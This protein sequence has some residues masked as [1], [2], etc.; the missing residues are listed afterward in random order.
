MENL[1]IAAQLKGITVVGTGD[2]T[3]PKWLS[4]ISEKLVPA[5]DGLYRIKDDLAARCDQNIPRSCRSTV[6]FVL[7]TEISNIYKKED[8]TR[9]NHNLIVV[10]DIE[11]ANRFSQRLDAIGNIHSDGRPILGLDAKNLL[12]ILLETS[13]HA[14]LIPAHIWTPW[15]SVMG[16]KSGF[17]SIE[18]CFE[19]LS[20]YIFAV[21][22]GLSSDPAMN[23][24]VSSL[25]KYTLISNSDAHSP[26]NLGREAN[27][28]DTE[29]SYHQIFFAIKNKKLKRF[30]GTYEFFPEEGKYH[31]DGHRKC[32]V[33]LSP[34]ESIQNKGIC[35][36]C[37]KPLTLGVL[38][39]VEELA[40]R[41]VN[42]TPEEQ[43]PFYRSIPLSDIL[44][45]ILKTGPKSK[46]VQNQYSSLLNEFGSEYNILHGIST[47]TL[48]S[49]GVPLLAEAIS[50]MRCG[51]LLI[52][53]GFDGEYG[54][55][56][57]FDPGERE[58]LIGQKTLFES[59]RKNIPEQRKYNRNLPQTD[60]EI[61]T[62]ISKPAAVSVENKKIENSELNQ[63]QLQAIQL[64]NRSLLIV[65]GPGTGKTLT[66][67]RRIAHL[68][69]T[70]DVL[71]ENILAVTFTNKAAREM[72]ERLA[73][74]NVDARQLPLITTF[75]GLCYRMLS[76][77]NPLSLEGSAQGS[78]HTVIDE[79][80]QRFY[81]NEAVDLFKS[82]GGCAPADSK[83]VL[84]HIR[85]AKQMLMEPDD[86][87]IADATNGSIGSAADALPGIYGSY[88]ELLTHQRLYD[89]EDL[90]FKTVK[91]LESDPVARKTYQ[92]R[93]R[94]I[95][96]DEF[97]DI[98]LGQHRLLQLLSGPD[99][100]ICAIGDPDQS[101]YGFRGSDTKFFNGF[102]SGFADTGVI[103]LTQNY[104]STRTIVEAS[105]QIIAGQPVDPLLGDKF[106][107]Q[108][109]STKEGFKT[110][111][112]IATA[113]ERAE[114]VAV[115][116]I[117]E[118]MIGGTGFHYVDFNR[119]ESQSAGKES[120]FSDFAVLY[121]TGIQG[122][123]FS[124]VFSAAG[125][126]HQ[127]VN[128]DSVY[129]D[130]GNSGAL[131]LL[132]IFAGAGSFM[133]LERLKDIISPGAPREILKQFR[134][135][136]FEN[137]MN[138]SESLKNVRRLP[139]QGMSK[140]GQK[141]LV[142]FLDRLDQLRQETQ[143]MTICETLQ[144]VAGQ[145]RPAGDV[146]EDEQSTLA[147]RAIMDLSERYGRRRLEFISALALQTDTDMYMPRSERVALMTM[148]SAKGLEFPVVF[149][150]GCENGYIPLQRSGSSAADIDEERRLFYVAMTRAKERLFFIF[151]RE[152]RIYG[153]KEKREASPFIAQIDS[154]LKEAQASGEKRKKAQR[155][156]K[157]F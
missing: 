149:I 72:H 63:E 56:Q 110:I 25:D 19:E 23:R 127:L 119:R 152:R 50:R 32:S 67:T 83:S 58:H 115:G 68:M 106:F 133:D 78:S 34:K 125:I 41:P 114:A 143:N 55:V 24:R 61:K 45:E 103:K 153:K 150:C 82:K 30:L 44:S 26:M 140:N 122:K 64:N 92:D 62:D 37:E 75:H 126:P 113:S 87:R 99:V 111:T 94:F 4:E 137:R 21:E 88:Q 136:S 54:K 73:G 151:A 11:T 18:E 100:R 12:E 43:P 16:S 97:Q 139:I 9:K 157:L 132:K 29:L 71:P 36:K 22:T 69:K 3:H 57:I 81:F 27:I 116:K 1:Y 5:E 96:V 35:P 146:Q 38:Y 20:E 108:N 117:I 42:V 135:W 6:R 79:T 138:L 131:S 101:I 145:I 123:I 7:S 77:L 142:R 118:A 104:R 124:D 28:F 65:A 134:W 93:F 76:E 39:R 49:A 52:E 105:C 60:P 98:N 128:R 48:K 8:K 31:L 74:L 156:L 109:Y 80:E 70:Q 144:H 15:F 17:D 14:V 10:P 46:A 13:Q 85:L 102:I 86:M 148:H 51:A 90:I 47:E 130:K 154:Q 66:L 129:S 53:P 95:F 2:F 59:P 121:R 112:L 141:Q 84:E 155:Q 147:F 120:S 107:R 89:F 33:R 40:D 91:R